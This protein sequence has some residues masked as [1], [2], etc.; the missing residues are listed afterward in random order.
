M[1]EIH[2]GSKLPALSK[3]FG[4]S[5][6]TVVLL[7]AS[8]A[9]AVLVYCVNFYRKRW[10]WYYHSWNVPG[11]LAYPFIGNA[12]KLFGDPV[13]K[14][15]YFISKPEYIE[16]IIN[17]PNVI[18][19][20]Y[21]Y[22]LFVDVFGNGILTSKGVKWKSHRKIMTRSFHQ[23]TLDAFIS[24]F[25]E[26]A[27]V[28][29]DILKK[30]S[31]KKDLP[32]LIE[33]FA[34]KI[35]MIRYQSSLIWNRSADK[36]A[37][38]LNAK[39][40]NDLCVTVVRKKMKDYKEKQQIESSDHV[41]DDGSAAEKKVML[42]LLI[43]S[44]D[45]TEEELKEEVTTTLAAGTETT[46]NSTVFILLIL[47]LYPDVQQQVFEEVMEVLGPEKSVEP[48]D[49]PK[50]EYTERVIK[51]AMRLFP[52]IAAVSRYVA[53]DT[54][55]GDYVAPAGIT[56]GFPIIH[57]HRSSIFWEDPMKF[58]PDRFLPEN[59]AKRHP[60]SYMPFSSGIRNCI[61]WRYAMMSLKT[62]IARIVRELKIFT[63]YKC[64][65]EIE[66]ELH[67]FTKIKHGPKVWFETR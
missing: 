16:K 58:D 50:L 67:V 3:L 29:V 53:E 23:K 10:K 19:K 31:E 20:D 51:E 36:K 42:D 40:I 43:E 48:E 18:D 11:P 26:E 28:F 15:I 34:R 64:I 41:F 1:A 44:S 47:G 46:A 5:S 66:L 60:L 33:I 56:I 57:I 39:T 37:F 38:L 13:R 54:Y 30:N 8:L 7:I 45:L 4:I 63:E 52:V 17:R 55:I 65:E 12:Y 49:L 6:L 32:L 14:L 62:L 24:I 22:D 2:H 9:F 25:D 27:T 61:G 35:F 21:F 59:A